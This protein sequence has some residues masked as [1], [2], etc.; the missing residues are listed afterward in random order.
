MGTK[1]EWAARPGTKPESWNPVTG[2][3]PVSAGCE[4]CYAKRLA[5]R[6]KAMGQPKYQ[7]GFKVTCHPEEVE[8]PGRWRKE[9]TV[10]VCSMSDLFHVAVPDEFIDRVFNTMVWCSEHTFIILTK[11]PERLRE[12][13]ALSVNPHIWAGATVEHPHSS[14]RFVDLRETPAAVKWVSIEPMLG[15]WGEWALAFQHGELP[16]YQVDWVV[17]GAETGPHK[18]PM[19]EKAALLIRDK[20]KEWNIPFFF[21]KNND[22]SR[23]L[24][25]R[26]YE[27]W[28]R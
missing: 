15:T 17:V 7:D 12:C 11:R 24:G 2:C 10:F 13:G 26:T 1:V 23:L 18:R 6:L 4:N 22:G 19:D 9:R 21:K 3:S 5:K 20:C 14:H 25:G 8:K 27:E 16:L 28:P